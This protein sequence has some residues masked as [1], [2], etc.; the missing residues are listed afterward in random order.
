MLSTSVG[1]APPAACTAWTATAAIPAT[2]AITSAPS[3]TPR[4]AHAALNSTEKVES[5]ASESSVTLAFIAAITMST[6]MASPRNMVSSRVR[7]R[8]NQVCTAATQVSSSAISATVSYQ[9]ESVPGYPVGGVGGGVDPSNRRQPSRS[10]A[11]SLYSALAP[12][13]FVTPRNAETA[14]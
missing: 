8:V 5:A 14:A 9:E 12:A 1:G 7:S 6:D 2:A 4:I 13:L 10:A 11:R 3:G